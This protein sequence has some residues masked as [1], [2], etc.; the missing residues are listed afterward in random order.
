MKTQQLSHKK[1]VIGVVDNPVTL[2]P[3]GLLILKKFKIE[4]IL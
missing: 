3:S 2:I 4:T 1:K